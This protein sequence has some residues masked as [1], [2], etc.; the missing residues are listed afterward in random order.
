LLIAGEVPEQRAL[1]ERIEAYCAYLDGK[2]KPTTIYSR[3]TDIVR[4]LSVLAPRMDV[5]F[6]RKRS[7]GYPKRGDRLAKPAR[8]QDLEVLLQLGLDLME[9]AERKPS[10]G[11]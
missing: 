6:I 8:M 4:A 9:E 11:P 1:P 10:F 7:Y 5:R 3:L 2:V